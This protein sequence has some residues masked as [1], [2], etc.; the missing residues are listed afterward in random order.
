MTHDLAGA[1]RLIRARRELVYVIVLGILGN[2]VM[3]PFYAVLSAFIAEYDLTQRAQALLFG[4]AATGY[5]L[6]LLTGSLLLLRWWRTGGTRRTLLLAT[7]AFVGV[8]VLVCSITLVHSGALLAGGLALC[9]LLF[10]V[11][12]SAAGSIWLDRTPAE[13]RVRVFA[14]RRLATFSSIPLG[15]MLMGFGGAAVGYHP[16]I[17]GLSAVVGVL[18]VA[19]W[20]IF[21]RRLPTEGRGEAET[22][23]AT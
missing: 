21:R 5:A 14:V 1:L 12:M 15:T 7:A 8:C 10:A 4:R 16:F 22:G 6:G 17:L 18:T 23:A 11:P 3:F 2:L 9:G 20:V 13:I 19:W